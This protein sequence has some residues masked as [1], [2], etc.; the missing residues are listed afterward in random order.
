MMEIPKGNNVTMT[1]HNYSLV[2][3]NIK[4]NF[5]VAYKLS[6][7]INENLTFVL[8]IMNPAIVIP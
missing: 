8:S 6:P 4:M 2:A 3:A 1:N 5:P 7:I